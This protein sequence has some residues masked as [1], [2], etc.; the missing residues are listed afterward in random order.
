MKILKQGATEIYDYT[1]EEI[2]EETCPICKAVFEYTQSDYKT[3][4]V[5][6]EFY[7]QQLTAY[8]SHF[9]NPY[10]STADLYRF[11][12]P[13]PLKT[14]AWRYITCPCCSYKIIQP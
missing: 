14:W 3:E 10:C 5:E 6:N 9:S 11:S 7:S 2:I 12:P 4:I 13:L 8:I 1:C